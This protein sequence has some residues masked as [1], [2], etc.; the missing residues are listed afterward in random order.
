VSDKASAALAVSVVAVVPGIYGAA[1]PPMS[2]ARGQADDRG[3]LAAAERYA[4]LLSAAVVLGIAGVTRSPEA[5]AVG[6][7]AVVGFSAA[8]R[9]AT[10]AT[11]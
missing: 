10:K 2:E 11:P 5:A 1:L 7:I 3:H 9:N 8:Y 4:A 6:L